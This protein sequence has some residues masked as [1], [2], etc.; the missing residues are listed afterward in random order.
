MEIHEK[1]LKAEIASICDVCK[2]AFLQ[3]TVVPEEPRVEN[4][5]DTTYND[6]NLELDNEK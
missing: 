6:L 4:A 1:N 3:N 2:K 5:V